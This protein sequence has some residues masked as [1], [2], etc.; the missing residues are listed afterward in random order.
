MP[1]KLRNIKNSCYINSILQCLVHLPE[2]NDW[3]RDRS[4]FDE[5]TKEFNDIRQLMLEPHTEI[6]PFRFVHYVHTTFHFQEGEP[7]DAHE[8][9]IQLLDHFDCPLFKGEKIYHLGE[10]I[11]KEAFHCLELFIPREGMSLLDCFTAY[12]VPEEVEY[13]GKK[14]VKRCDLQLPPLLAIVLVRSRANH[15]KNEWV[16]SIPSKL[17][18]YELVSICNHYGNST[19]GHYTATVLEDKWYEC[20]DDHIIELPHI[21]VN[22]AYCLF[23]RKKTC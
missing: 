3:F 2:L 14:V 6:S 18:P 12:C 8:L 21:N 9:L 10:S 19:H 22:H 15:Q 23:F 1:T 17:G 11:T 16:V 7:N 4:E 5:I 13:E 20:N